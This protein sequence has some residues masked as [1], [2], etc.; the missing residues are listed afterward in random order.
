MSG[1]VTSSVVIPSLQLRTYL[2][3]CTHLFLIT[4]AHSRITLL[5]QQSPAYQIQL[6]QVINQVVE[7]FYVRS[8][9]EWFKTQHKQNLSWGEYSEWW[10][11]SSKHSRVGE[12]L[13]REHNIHCLWVAPCF[14]TIIYIQD[15]LYCFRSIK[16]PSLV[17]NVT[18]TSKILA[19]KM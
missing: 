2:D 15:A 5:I 11:S 13:S 18:K 4:I 3:L 12:T 16:I 6:L 19:K 1:A 8:E 10:V 17:K 9:S 7:E 14:D